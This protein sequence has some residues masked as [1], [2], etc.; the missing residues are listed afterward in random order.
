MKKKLINVF[1]IS[2]LAL[3]FVGSV[4]SVNASA[5][6][7]DASTEYALPTVTKIETGNFP[8]VIDKPVGPTTL[9]GIS[10]M[11]LINPDNLLHHSDVLVTMS[12]GTQL[13][14]YNEDLYVDASQVLTYILR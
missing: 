8:Y 2:M 7:T 6:T 5:A 13:L 14:R 1:I 4:S 9:S 12:D 3:G 10:L 11:M